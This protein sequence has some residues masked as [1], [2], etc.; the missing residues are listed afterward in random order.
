[1]LKKLSTGDGKTGDATNFGMFKQN[2]LILR[3]SAYKFKG[4][5]EAQVSNGAILK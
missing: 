3:T 4:Q 1:M 5:T 2:W